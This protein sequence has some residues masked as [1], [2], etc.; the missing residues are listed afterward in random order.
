MHNIISFYV[1]G[2][3]EILYIHINVLNSVDM[4]QKTSLFKKMVY[5]TCHTLQEEMCENLTKV[6]QTA[7]CVSVC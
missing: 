2:S 7:E 6:S 3:I 4:Q 1:E 5:S